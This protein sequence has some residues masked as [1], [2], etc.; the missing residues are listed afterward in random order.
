MTNR[1]EYGT[2]SFAESSELTSTIATGKIVADSV[3]I[4]RRV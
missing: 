4:E 3:V 1:G 2:V